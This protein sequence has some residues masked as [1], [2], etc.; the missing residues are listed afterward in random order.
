MSRSLTPCSRVRL[1]GLNPPLTNNCL[2]A[3]GGGISRPRHSFKDIVS[4]QHKTWA[5]LFPNPD[6]SF[7]AETL[8]C[9]LG[10]VTWPP[11][12]LFLCF[13]VQPTRCGWPTHWRGA[14]CYLQQRCSGPSASLV[15]C[16]AT[17]SCLCRAPPTLH[18]SVDQAFFSAPPI[19]GNALLSKRPPPTVPER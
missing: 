19:S 13:F 7:G 16:C 15:T 10:G 18:S 8:L 17:L 12:F 14:S 2:A 6:R 4:R 9:L 1:S 3:A 5:A 11:F